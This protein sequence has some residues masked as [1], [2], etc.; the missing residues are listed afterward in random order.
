M[1]WCGEIWRTGVESSSCGLRRSGVL[2]GRRKR[3]T[4]SLR[5][6]NDDDDDDDDVVVVSFDGRSLEYQYVKVKRIP[7]RMNES[8]SDREE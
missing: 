2:V 6:V 3:T 8:M 5:Y 4:E 7:G 1:V